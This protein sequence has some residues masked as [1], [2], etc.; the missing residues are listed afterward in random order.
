[1]APEGTPLASPEESLPTPKKGDRM[2]TTLAVTLLFAFALVSVGLPFRFGAWCGKLAL[3][4]RAKA[5]ERANLAIFDEGPERH[6]QYVRWMR[7]WG[8]VATFLAVLFSLFD[9]A[10]F[11]NKPVALSGVVSSTIL[12]MGASSFVVMTLLAYTSLLPKARGYATLA[13][14][15]FQAIWI[16]DSRQV[17]TELRD[18]LS[19][20]VKSSS[21]VG[22]V[23]VTG[24][25]LLGKGPGPSGGLLYDVLHTMTGVPVYLLLVQPE[26]TAID[27][28]QR[29]AT[30]FQT[31]LAEME[32]TPATLVRK[33][34]STL[35]AVVALNESRPAETK[36]SVRFYNEKPTCRAIVFDESVLVSPWQ[37]K[38]NMPWPVMEVMRKA[39]EA[40]LYETFRR[41]FARLWAFSLAEGELPH[42][43][44]G[45]GSKAIRKPAAQ[46]AVTA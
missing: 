8:G 35:E 39:P 1:M 38:E 33:I 37:P 21:M 19:S 2:Y 6:L 9:T 26:A 27:P 15:G 44:N 23:D 43:G 42:S 14:A 28:E 11:T 7:V 29:K 34:R 10:F 36:I 22:I 24:H 18:G 30:V 46:E 41:H 25:E 5:L 17:P 3:H 45:T 32:T 12:A 13:R 4:V 31:L 40:S 16:T 20:C